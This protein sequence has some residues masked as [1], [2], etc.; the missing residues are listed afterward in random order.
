LVQ[1]ATGPALADASGWWRAHCTNPKRQRGPAVI[2][3]G[4]D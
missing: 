4:Q 3:D 2:R 1:R